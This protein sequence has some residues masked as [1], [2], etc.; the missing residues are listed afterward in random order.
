MT[1]FVRTAIGLSC[2]CMLSVQAQVAPG[3]N[4]EPA[5]LSDSAIHADY[6]TYEAMQSRIKALNDRGVGVGPKVSD[7]HLGKAQCWLDVSFHEYARNDRSEFPQQALEQSDR[8]VKLM[9]AD[10]RP[11]PDDTPLV[12]G[13]DRLRPDLWAAAE[14]LKRH[15]GYRCAAARVACAEVELVH[16][17]NEHMQLGWRHAKPYVQMAEDHLA[18]AEA[19]ARQCIPP[20]APLPPPPASAPPAP[21]PEAVSYSASLLFDFAAADAASILPMTRERLN[22]LL[23][24]TRRSGFKL[25]Q[26]TVT[27]FTDRLNASGRADFNQQLSLKRAQ[28]VADLLV[29]AGIDGSR[30]VVQGKADANPVEL[31]KQH[32]SV[33]AALKDCLAPNRR[34]EVEVR[35]QRLR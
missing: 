35:G 7:Y 9:Q 21:L 22:Q 27:G 24:R 29:A 6:K 20:P 23:E 12:N 2:L 18:D 16:A 1:R 30:I 3:L 14:A 10:T 15:E 13:A 19:A 31:C 28:T 4:A 32:F 5:R 34:V 26:A 8:L 25:E 17:G 11:L 33:P